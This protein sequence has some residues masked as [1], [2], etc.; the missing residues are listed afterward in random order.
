MD[1]NLTALFD[2]PE[3][4]LGG[5]VLSV[6]V[7]VW[8]ARR[9][10]RIAR[11][12][13]P[14][15][16]LSNIAMLIGFGWS[17]EAV[18]ELTSRIG[19]GLELQIPLFAVL[20]LLLAMAMIRVKRNIRQINRPGR[21]GGTAWLIAS[22]MALVAGASSGS[23]PEAAL[24]IIIPLLVVRTWWDGLL[25]EGAKRSTDATSW[26]WTPRRL[27]LWLGAI[28]PGERDV[29][30]VNRER[31]TQQMTALE[32]RRRHGSKRFTQR[33]STKLA[34]LSLAADDSMIESVRERVDRAL[35]FE[36]K[37]EDA[38]PAASPVAVPA[39]LAASRK[40][41]RVLHRRSLRTL[42]LTHP[43][44][45]FTAAQPVSADDRTTQEKH[46]AA[47]FIK[48]AAPGLSQGQIARLLATSPATVGR[49]LRS[50]N[51]INGSNPE[52]EAVNT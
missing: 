11:S 38:P 24:R 13:R 10:R 52:L 37:H 49:A 20:E 2:R 45:R 34:R 15:D 6:L 47:R 33:R 4:L 29:E 30:S 46:E 48:S 27:G 3:A 42:K 16:Q 7:L 5:L 51:S 44:P 1:I 8:M 14:D 32:F 28:E 26:R 35:W 50:A 41:R 19:F 40:G 31:L 25:P 21:A 43:K 23:I 18:W 39:R 36:A 22:G 12:E 17:S 9:V